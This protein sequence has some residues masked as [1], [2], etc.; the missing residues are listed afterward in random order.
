MSQPNRETFWSPW[1]FHG[2]DQS[3]IWNVTYARPHGVPVLI[4]NF[5]IPYVKLRGTQPTHICLRWQ[6]K[7]RASEVFKWFSSANPLEISLTFNPYANIV[8]VRSVRAA[9]HTCPLQF[10][11]RGPFI[12]ILHI[13]EWSQHYYNSCWGKCCDQQRTWWG[14]MERSRVVQ[15]LSTL[16]H[17]FTF[18]ISTRCLWPKWNASHWLHRRCEKYPKE[19]TKPRFFSFSTMGEMYC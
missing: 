18:I 7:E 15:I 14:E 8:N 13:P 11:I 2:Q 6:E 9:Y 1:G 17:I 10:L 3:L 19:T 12:D 4:S 16:P 5:L